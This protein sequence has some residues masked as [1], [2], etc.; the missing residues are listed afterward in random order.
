LLSFLYVV[1]YF[2]QVKGCKVMSKKQLR[3]LFNLAVPTVL[4]FGLIAGGVHYVVN[5]V[6]DGEPVEGVGDTP[7][8]VEDESL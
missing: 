2:K 6:F 3:A 4:I 7:G 1:H 5:N 8:L